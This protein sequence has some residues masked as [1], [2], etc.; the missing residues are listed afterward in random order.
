MEINSCRLISL[1]EQPGIGID[2][3]LHR[4]LLY[5]A[6]RKIDGNSFGNQIF[7][8]QESQ[9]D[10][11]LVTGR[12]GGGRGNSH[13]RDTTFPFYFHF[14]RYLWKLTI[15]WYLFN[16]KIKNKDIFISFKSLVLIFW[17]LMSLHSGSLSLLVELPTDLGGLKTYL[18]FRRRST[19]RPNWPRIL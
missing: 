12:R 17:D 2:S 4:R 15:S 11:I 19:I 8:N 10:V 14:T 9:R 7:Q 5:P 13:Q 16:A 1:S 6:T 18:K 3:Q